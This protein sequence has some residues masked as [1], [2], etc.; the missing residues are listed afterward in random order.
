MPGWV[1]TLVDFL[2]VKATAMADKLSE[3]AWTGFTK[4]LIKKN[5]KLD[6]LKPKLDDKALLSALKEFDKTDDAKPEP[7][8]KALDE[9]I[10]QIP[11]QIKT[12]VKR[13]K[14]VGDKPFGDAKDKLYELLQEAESLHKR[15]AAHLADAEAEQAAKDKEK[16]KAKGKGEDE[17][18]DSPALLTTKMIPLLRELK[19]GEVVMPFLLALAG[20]ESVVLVSRR[21]ISPARGK[22]LKEQMAQPSG[23][24]FIRGECQYEKQALTFVVQSPG[25]ALAKRLRQA[26]L[27]QTGMRWKVRVRGED[28]VEEEDGEEEDPARKPATAEQQAYTQRL[29]KVR[30]RYQQ[31][32]REQHPRAAQYKALMDQA[33]AKANEQQDHAGA[34]Q[35][36]QAL[37]KA[38]DEGGDTGAKKPGTPGTPAAPGTPGTP[39]APGTPKASETPTKPATG[40]PATSTAP[41]LAPDAL[42]AQ[43]EQR[44]ATMEPRVLAVLKAQT[45]DASKIR[46]VAEFVREKGD[47][48]NYKAALA[49]MESLEK[50]L[51]AAGSGQ[52]QGQA[53]GTTKAEP[54][55]E[56]VAVPHMVL[57]P[58]WDT[59]SESVVEQAGELIV[60]MREEGDPELD[61]MADDLLATVDDK[62]AELSE[63]LEEFDAL[64]GEEQADVAADLR[65]AVNRI[66]RDVAGDR[67][68]A[69]ADQNPLGVKTT[70]ARTLRDALQNVAAALPA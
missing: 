54:V 7:R 31:A 38:M 55:A 39:A 14:E 22:L 35:A 8:L 49:G 61:R 1:G 44:L 5:P 17:E 70:L 58:I 28:G 45:G 26:L 66:Q 21:A 18:E 23:L 42:K 16:E 47:S 48:Q 34:I 65:S 20:K 60:K 12:W 2:S 24:K 9:L 29:L 36:L 4:D 37:E 57:S 6:E 50:L 46:A 43:Y 69:A 10:K 63:L 32:L 59:A 68:M 30:D 13:K 33:T 25:A 3:S 62:L 64:T 52:V 56:A 15:V 40:T 11:E 41:P 27:D 51:A 67:L 19:K 53:Q